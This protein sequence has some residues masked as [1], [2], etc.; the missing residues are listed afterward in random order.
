MNHL[1]QM[2]ESFDEKFGKATPQELEEIKEQ[3]YDE[4]QTDC[5]GCDGCIYNIFWREQIKGFYRLQHIKFLEEQVERFKELLKKSEGNIEKLDEV[6][7]RS[8][9]TNRLNENLQSGYRI[10]LLDQRNYYQQLLSELKDK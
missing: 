10:G 2:E 8:R 4:T 6:D 1:H 5:A 3:K 7:E 9:M